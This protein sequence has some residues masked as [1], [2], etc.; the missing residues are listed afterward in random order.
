MLR[1]VDPKKE[2]VKN[3]DLLNDLM[4]GLNQ[5]WAPKFPF[6]SDGVLSRPI[7]LDW[8]PAAASNPASLQLNR[9]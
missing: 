5:Q 6:I 9:L 2:N 4:A 3:N 1:E 8:A 7:H